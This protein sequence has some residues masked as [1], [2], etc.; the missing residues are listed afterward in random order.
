MLSRLV[1]CPTIAD[2]HCLVKR[3]RNVITVARKAGRM[4][5]H[6]MPSYRC[7][8]RV[9]GK[10]GQIFCDGLTW[11]ELALLAE[12][13]QRNGSEGFRDRTDVEFCFRCDVLFQFYVGI[14]IG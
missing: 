14:A 12:L 3:R 6:V 8:V 5:H 10:P 9:N 11:V 2:A 7:V 4:R 13:K 1:S